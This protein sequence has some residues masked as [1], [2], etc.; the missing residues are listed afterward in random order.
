[1]KVWQQS[2]LS[3]NIMSWHKGG[4]TERMANIMLCRAV[5][6]TDYTTYLDGK[7]EHGKDALIFRLDALEELPKMIKERLNQ[8]KKLEKIAQ[9]GFEKSATPGTAGQK[10]FWRG[11]NGQDLCDAKFHAAL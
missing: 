3:L 11:C 4:F 9:S 1:M 6:V 2:R 7:F 10:N 8:P 5:L